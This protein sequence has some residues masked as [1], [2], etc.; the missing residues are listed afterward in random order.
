MTAKK[1]ATLGFRVK[2]G[3]AIA[4]L[5]SGSKSL[6]QVLEHRVILLS[7]PAYPDTIQ[8][9]HARMGKLEEDR[10][11]IKRR[12]GIIERAAQKSVTDIL[13]EY[14]SKG[15]TIRAAGLVVG[16]LIDPAAIGN[17]H[18]R[19]HALE[20]RLF[21]TVLEKAL[22]RKK[23]ASSLFLQRDIYPRATA[24][25]GITEKELKDLLTDL[26]R[27]LEGPWRADEKSAALAAWMLLAKRTTYTAVK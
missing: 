21:R 6:P 2:S 12:T 23:V 22:R 4:V 26:G 18:V 19:A 9:Y 8:P 24:A 10:A 5:M 11:K 7:D 15:Y 3:R 1:K 13:K 17:P 27:L 20:G 14:R 16:S 25:L